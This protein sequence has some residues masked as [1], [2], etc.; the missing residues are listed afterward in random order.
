MMKLR[1]VSE[2]DDISGKTVLLVTN[3]D[4]PVKDELVLNNFRIQ[5]AIP[6]LKLLQDKGARIII[7]SKLGRPDGKYQDDMSL[8]PVRFEL[9]RL[10]DEHIKFAHIP[11]SR[12]SIVFMENRE[13]L[14]LENSR[15][16]PGE[17]STKPAERKEFI[18]ELAGLADYYVNDDFATYRPSATNHELA[19]MVKNPMAGLLMQQEVEQ[20]SKLHNPDSTYVAVIGGAKLDTKIPILQ[21]LIG[22]ADTILIGGAMAYTFLKAQGIETGKSKIQPDLLKQAAKI[23]A[24]AKKAGTEIVLPVDHVAA[25]EFG[26]DAAPITVDT[27][28]IPK[29]LIAMDIGERTMDDYQHRIE[30]AKTIMWNGPMGVFE[31][32]QFSRGTEAIGEY[33]GLAAPKSTFKVA[34]G[35]DTITAMEKLKINFKNYNHISTGG[36][37]MLAFLAGEE[38]PTLQPLMKK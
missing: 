9:G 10:M 32:E 24:D 28:Q 30:T 20:L 3:L 11:T 13:V 16:H 5:A 12:N 31:F 29:D 38:F 26:E 8:M 35:G 17:E 18:K 34:G 33:I 22:K 25:K 4:V 36:G 15:F 27:Q 2:L 21:S 14:L 19:M 6:T 1:S 37:A 23:L 7:L